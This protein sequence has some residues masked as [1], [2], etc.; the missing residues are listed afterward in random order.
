MVT[1][2]VAWAEKGKV[3]ELTMAVVVATDAEA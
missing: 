1:G 2:G 3:M